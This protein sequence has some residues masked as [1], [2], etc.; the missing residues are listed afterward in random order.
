MTTKQK[1]IQA[2]PEA[3]EK[4]A[5][6]VN[7]NPV[8]SA[9]GTGGDAGDTG[10]VELKSIAEE[11]AREFPLLLQGSGLVLYDVDP[12][13]LQVQ[14]QISPDVLARARSS[15]PPQSNVVGLILRLQRLDAEGGPREL[16][17][18][19][20]K[21]GAA[22]LQGQARFGVDGEGGVYQVE[23]GMAS[24]DGGWLLLTRSNRV[25]PPRSPEATVPLGSAPAE[26]EVFQADHL[27]MIAPGLP[28]E[29]EPSAKSER[30]SNK[31]FEATSQESARVAAAQERLWDVEPAL[32]AV[33]R[34]LEPVFPLPG[35]VEPGRATRP[36]VGKAALGSEADTVAGDETRTPELPTALQPTHSGDAGTWA[37]LPRPLLPSTPSMDDGEWSAAASAYEPRGALSSRELSQPG[38]R[39]PDIEF[40]AELRVWGRAAPGSLIDIFGREVQV[41]ADGRFSL[42]CPMDDPLL[43][44][45]ALAASRSDSE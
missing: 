1:N 11:I 13:H 43:L 15:F 32:A 3:A 9:S 33:G 8:P 44:T 31:V 18:L 6:E 5:R 37:E 28:F 30:S 24:A 38:T 29:A 19:T 7:S 41:G 40:N 25:Q 12:Y 16:A 35:Q 21:A 34:P 20:R 17:S 10:S 42:R 26:D 14:W 36:L 22:G 45:S 39:G 2:A 27:E 4:P 23:L